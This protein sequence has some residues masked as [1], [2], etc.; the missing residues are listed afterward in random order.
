[1]NYWGGSGFN[2]DVK[3][4]TSVSSGGGGSG[5]IDL[6]NL[7]LAAFARPEACFDFFPMMQCFQ[8]QR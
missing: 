4:L 3:S 1:M 7:R 6:S 8:I 2:E 5:R